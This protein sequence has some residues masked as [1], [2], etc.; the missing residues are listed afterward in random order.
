MLAL[1]SVVSYSHGM[2]Y[3]HFSIIG[4]VILHHSWFGSQVKCIHACLVL[5]DVVCFMKLREIFPLCY[6]NTLISVVWAYIQY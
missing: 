2:L 3:L 4:N 6:R 5:H 1:I